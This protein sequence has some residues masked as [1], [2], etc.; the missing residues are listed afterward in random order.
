MIPLRDRPVE[1]RTILDFVPLE[2]RHLPEVIGEDTR[3]DEARNTPADDNRMSDLI[4][5]A[6]GSGRP[7][8]VPS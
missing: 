5:K 2:N 3:G 6:D 4:H 7:A 8:T 1:N